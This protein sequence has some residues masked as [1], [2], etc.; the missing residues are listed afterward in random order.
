MDRLHRPFYQV[1]I[2]G[3]WV[4]V[5]EKTFDADAKRFKM[6]PLDLDHRVFEY[7]KNPLAFFLPHGKPRR[8]TDRDDGRA[9]INDWKHELLLLRAPSKTGKTWAGAAKAG[10]FAG[11]CDPSWECYGRVHGI[12]HREWPGPTEGI[13]SSFSFDNVAILWNTYINLWPRE[14]LGVFAPGWGKF[15]CEKGKPRML[16]FGDG[17]RK[18][19]ELPCGV[20]LTMLCDTQSMVHWESRMADWGHGDEQLSEDKA[21]ILF[22]RFQTSKLDYNPV[23]FTATPFVVE[24][25]PDTGAGNWLFRGLA[26]GGKIMGRT[27]KKYTIDMDSVPDEIVSRDKKKKAYQQNIVEPEQRHDERAIRAGKARYYAI[28]ETGGGLVLD[29]FVRDLSVVKQFDVFSHKPTLYRMIDHGRNPCAALVF[30]VMPWGDTVV[31]GEHYDFGH[32]IRHNAEK[33]VTELCGNTIRKIDEFEHEGLMYPICEEVPVTMPFLSSEIDARSYN[34]QT[35][36]SGLLIGTL[37]NTFGC[38]CTPANAAHDQHVQLNEMFALEKGRVHLNERLKRK[39]P[40]DAKRFGSPRMYITANCIR[41]IAEIEGWMMKPKTGKPMDKDDHLCSAA[42]FYA[43]C[44][45][46]YQGWCGDIMG[47]EET[48]EIERDPY[49][50]YP[51]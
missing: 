16:R 14:W 1:P 2:H 47:R 22:S 30:A 4:R 46:D 25:R 41:F 17:Q 42:K 39:V 26:R 12:K 24:N 20:T 34:T 43:S 40:E 31:Y 18:T 23:W 33:I 35:N 10:Y 32:G 21:G 27:A 45:R 28:P 44:S 11:P 5:T 48:K 29:E 51:I 7:Q 50:G 8:G 38:T 37:Y 49:T 6:T 3:K 19:V 13:L 15:P 36:E 9:F